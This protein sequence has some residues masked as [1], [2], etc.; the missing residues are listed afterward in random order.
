[1]CPKRCMDVVSGMGIEHFIDTWWNTVSQSWVVPPVLVTLICHYGRGTTHHNSRGLQSHSTH[2]WVKRVKPSGVTANPL[3]LHWVSRR[4]SPAMAMPVVI[5]LT[6]CLNQ[7]SPS[8]IASLRHLG[9]TMYLEVGIG[10]RCW[11]IQRSSLDLFFRFGW[12]GEGLFCMGN[13]INLRPLIDWRFRWNKDFFFEI[14]LEDEQ[15]S[16][17][18]DPAC[19]QPSVF[20]SS[21]HRSKRFGMFPHRIHALY[22][23]LRLP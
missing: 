19:H 16:M 7:R 8:G 22:I 1:M 18:H 9:E 23:Y 2:S 11:N 17:F 12:V 21:C 5:P 3:W 13:N 10:S 14:Q 4:A 6:V 15:S 20:S